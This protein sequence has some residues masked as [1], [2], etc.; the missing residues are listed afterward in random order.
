MASAFAAC[1]PDADAYLGAIVNEARR[2][3]QLFCTQ[4]EPLFAITNQTRRLS[5]T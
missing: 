4:P 2:E 5:A 3:A 1:L